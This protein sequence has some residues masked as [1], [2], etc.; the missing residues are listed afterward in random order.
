MPSEISKVDQPFVGALKSATVLDERLKML[1]KTRK[2]WA[3]FTAANLIVF[4]ILH[5][6]DIRLRFS[7]APSSPGTSLMLAGMVFFGLQTLAAHSEIRTLIMFRHLSE[8][9]KAT[10]E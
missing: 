10:T 3:W 1:R 9:S 6:M 8:L 4:F 5:F 7:G 2:V